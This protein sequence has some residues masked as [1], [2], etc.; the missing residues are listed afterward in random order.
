VTLEEALA[1]DGSAFSE[2]WNFGREDAAPWSVSRVVEVMGSFWGLESAWL[3][4][5]ARHAREESLLRLDTG[6]SASR[7]GWRC[8]LPTEEA[9][10]SV[11]Q[12]YQGYRAK[13]DPRELCQEQ[14]AEFRARAESAVPA[15]PSAPH[16]MA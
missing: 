6:K 10:R 14:I 9:L 5:T 11:V 2:P 7:L 4:D 15:G 3:R 1:R 8:K 13:R 12:W 16:R